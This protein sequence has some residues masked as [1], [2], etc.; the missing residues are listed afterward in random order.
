MRILIVEDNQ[1]YAEALKTALSMIE[2]YDVVDCVSSGRAALDF[3]QSNASGVDSVLLDLRL[4]EGN[5]HDILPQLKALMPNCSVI[6]LSQ[7]GKEHDVVQAINR[8]ADGYL[9]KSSTAVQIIDALKTVAEGG[10]PIDAQVAGYL[11]D[12]FRQPSESKSDMAVL[13]SRELEILGLLADG[14]TKKEIASHLY[15]SYA[16]V[17]SHV[18]NVYGKLN[19]RNVAEAISKGYKSGLIGLD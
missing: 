4:P 6:V 18:R 19:A 15:V 16:T 9:L 11:L 5:G 10:A 13:T 12:R 7:S 3:A 17:D 14:Q 1:G 8:G 2:G